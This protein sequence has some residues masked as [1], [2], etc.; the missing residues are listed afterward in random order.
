MSLLGEEVVEEWLN[1]QGYF[2]I[3]GIKLGVHEIDLLAIKPLKT[4]GHDRRHIEVSVS[5]N[6]ISYIAGLPKEVAKKT[7]RSPNAAGTRSPAD[8]QNGAAEWIAKKFN[9]TEKDKLRQQLCPGEWS[10]ELVVH[11]LKHEDE[12]RFFKNAGI[13][14]HRLGDIVAEMMNGETLIKSASGD[15]LVNLMLLGKSR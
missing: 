7:G 10:K 5:I 4:G 8:I 1:R 3:R 6:P 9:L 15:D 2:T 14:I 12:L 13:Q 11:R